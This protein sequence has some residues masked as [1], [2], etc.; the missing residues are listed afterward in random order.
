MQVW[1]PRHRGVEQFSPSPSVSEWRS[2]AV[3]GSPRPQ[4]SAHRARAAAGERSGLRTGVSQASRPSRFSPRVITTVG[5]GQGVGATR[6]DRSSAGLCCP[7]V[8][9]IAALACSQEV[10]G[11]LGLAR[12]GFIPAL[13]I[14]ELR[15]LLTGPSAAGVGPHGDPVGTDVSPCRS[16]LQTFPGPRGRACPETGLG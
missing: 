6:Q 15:R 2:P 12:Q 9:G 1:K 10:W 14:L 3:L 4:G 13:R 7:L 11:C 5:L 8:A 16:S